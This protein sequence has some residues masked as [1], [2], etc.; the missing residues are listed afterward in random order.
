MDMRHG[1]DFRI[2]RPGG[3]GD[4]LLIIFKTNAFIDFGD[5]ETA[6]H[7]C[8]A[9]VYTKGKKQL[10]GAAG[11]AYVNDFLHFDSEGEKLSVPV[12]TLIELG[13]IMELEEILRLISREQMSFSSGRDECLDMLIKILM[14]KLR[15]AAADISYVP[16]NIHVSELSALRAEMYSSPGRFERV[17]QLAQRLNFSLS[18]F[19]QLYKTVFGV[20]CYEDLLSAKI[21]SAQYYL[22]T[23]GLSVK[24]IAVLCGYENDVCFMRRFKQRTGMTALEYRRERGG[25]QGTGGY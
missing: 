11:T 14:L 16:R 20:S 10:Y 21:R 17:E 7:P 15:D 19:Q 25:T 2:D 6:V 3:S 24:E 23:T 13:S 1:G 8:S 12:D 4:D 9:V 5:G 18:H 22:S